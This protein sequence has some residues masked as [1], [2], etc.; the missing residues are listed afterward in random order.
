MRTGL[1]LGTGTELLGKPRPSR[2]AVLKFILKEL[3]DRDSSVGTT[4]YRLDGPGIESQWWRDFPQPSR[5]ALGPTKPLLRR[6]L[7]LF[8]G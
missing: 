3:V 2:G 6:I 4:R 1:W 5:P 8:R 7:G